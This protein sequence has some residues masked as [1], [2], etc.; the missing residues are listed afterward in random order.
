MHLICNS[1]ALVVFFNDVSFRST[2]HLALVSIG[3]HVNINNDENDTGERSSRRKFFVNLPHVRRLSLS[4]FLRAQPK[5][6]ISVERSNNFWE[7]DH[8][9][10][11][12]WPPERLTVKP[13]SLEGERELMKELLRFRQ[14]SVYTEVIYL[15]P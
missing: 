3:L 12:V 15:G 14:A 8:Y 5:E 9:E 6:Q 11:A 10:L 4:Y 2:F 7:D 13:A 1:L